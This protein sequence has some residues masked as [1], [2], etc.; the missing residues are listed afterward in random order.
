MRENDGEEDEVG[1][2]MSEN[3]ICNYVI[4]YNGW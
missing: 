4:V 1:E 3:M 2:I